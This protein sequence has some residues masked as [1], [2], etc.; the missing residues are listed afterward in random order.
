MSN[1][2][3]GYLQR[4]LKTIQKENGKLKGEVSKRE[5]SWL[6]RRGLRSARKARTQ[7]SLA[8][9]ILNPVSGDHLVHPDRRPLIR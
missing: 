8:I 6:I 9:D 2:I 1:N 5:R 3:L 7:L 4:D